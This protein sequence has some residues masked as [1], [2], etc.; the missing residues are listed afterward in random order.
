[1]PLPKPPASKATLLSATDYET[2]AAARTAKR[3]LQPTHD[4]GKEALALTNAAAAVAGPRL[5]AKPAAPKA[6]A[7]TTRR[8]KPRAAR[9]AGPK[10]LFVLD[11]NVLM[12]DPLCLFRSGRA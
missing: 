5:E 8:G 4:P 10:R 12:H 6:A 2:Q 11:T 3:S 9:P 7:A 1:M